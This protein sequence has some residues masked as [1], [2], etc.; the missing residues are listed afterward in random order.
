M[1]SIDAL[2]PDSEQTH[3]T[4][5][6]KWSLSLISSIAIA[7]LSS[8]QY[9]YH[10]AE[11]NAPEKLI[12]T[13]LQL[14]E[15]QISLIT[16]IF[17]IGGLVSSTLAS[18]LSVGHGLKV[19]FILTSVFYILGSFIE[20]QAHNYFQM[21]LGRFFSGIGGGLAIVFVPLYVNE[22]SPLNLRGFLGSMTQVSVNLGIL[23][24][25]S[26]ALIWSINE[27]WRNI[28]WM[29]VFI[30]CLDLLLTLL[31]LE[32]SPKW[33]VL[34]NNN[35]S[36]G[37]RALTKLR[38]G[39]IVTSK[40]EI[41]SWKQEQKRHVESVQSNPQLKQLNL[42]TYLT[43][44][45][46]RNSRLV[47]TFSVLG[48]QFAG[49]NS[50]IFYG[51]KILAD[52]FPNWA[53]ALNCFISIGNTVITF[54]ASLFLDRVGRKPMLL[55]SVFFM[56]ISLVGLSGGIIF[57]QSMLTIISIF[58][59]VGSFAIGCGPIPFLL[60]SEV[61]QVEVKDLAQSWATNCN[62]VSV[63]IVGSAFP[64]LNESIGGYT[65]II[66]AAV[67]LAFGLFIKQF[68]PETKGKETYSE[69]WNLNARED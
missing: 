9:G 64:I 35:D 62:W 17:S 14:N 39:D 3:Q 4:N 12:R 11:L 8:I 52:V 7:C 63:F 21:L 16:S 46:Y 31:L 51:V 44:P 50:V 48:Q 66:F 57:H 43:Q 5:S 40:W 24:T 54:G 68:I 28:L 30:G 20:S 49:I 45:D 15:S 26:L 53:V 36:E 2:I 60:V 10:M 27:L 33:L 19:S 22:V 58:T 69:V 61:S 13:S 55:T 38:N 65:Y 41:D 25:Q 23:L 37:I 67:C 42:Y 6:S 47:A 29:G 59:Y 18:T 34:N 1:S 32:E 56:G